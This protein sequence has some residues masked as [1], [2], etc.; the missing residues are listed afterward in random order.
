MELTGK[1]MLT[2]HEFITITHDDG[3]S[4]MIDGELISGPGSGPTNP[5]GDGVVFAGKTGTHSFDLVYANSCG[6]GIL[7]F[8]PVM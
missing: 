1:V 5:V 6:S 3:V 8:S 7:S 4:L 2:A